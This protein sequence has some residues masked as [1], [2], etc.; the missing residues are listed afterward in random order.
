MNDA[1]Y[2]D[3]SNFCFSYA[4][5][6]DERKE[7]A[8]WMI[9]KKYFDMPVVLDTIEDK[10]LKAYNSW[11]I[12]LYI[13]HEGTIAFCGDQGPFGYSPSSLNPVLQRLTNKNV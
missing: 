9:S 7:M 10:L 8:K 3:E 12:R 1:E 13:I 11:P 6:I 2:T 4:K 5:G